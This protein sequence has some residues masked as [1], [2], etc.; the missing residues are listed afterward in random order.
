[1]LDVRDRIHNF[2][3]GIS[4]PQF[5][6]ESLFDGDKHIFI[7]GGGQYTAT[8]REIEGFKIRSTTKKTDP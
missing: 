3:T 8:F 1:M 7:D 5:I 4:H 6:V 2:C